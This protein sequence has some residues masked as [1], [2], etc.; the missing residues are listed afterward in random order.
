MNNGEHSLI[1]RAHLRQRDHLVAAL[2]AGGML[3]VYL[4]TAY[5]GVGGRACPGDAAKFQY[6]PRVL[7]VPHAPGF[8]LVVMLGHGWAAL[9]GG[10]APAPA[11]NCFSALWMAG[12]LALLFY[13]LRAVGVCWTAAVLASLA[14]AVSEQVWL[15]ATEAG[16]QALSV[17][18]LMLALCALLHW[19]AS[20]R[21]EWLLGVIA[22]V[23]LGAGHATVLLWLAPVLLV[24][25]VLRRPQAWLRLRPW[26]TLAGVLAVNVLLYIW[27]W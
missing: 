3:L 21:T 17:F 19:F 5:P 20:A 8:P 7:G 24:A 27:L 26:L 4:A 25:T 12:A 23:G 2:L 11:M 18:L 10:E 22:A 15:S 13:G 9:A 16:P 1:W 14:Y 6:I